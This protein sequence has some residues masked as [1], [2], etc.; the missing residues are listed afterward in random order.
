LDKNSGKTILGIY[1]SAGVFSSFKGKFIGIFGTDP[2]AVFITADGKFFTGSF[3]GF[4][5]VVIYY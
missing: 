2:A 3:A 5:G 4:S 1:E